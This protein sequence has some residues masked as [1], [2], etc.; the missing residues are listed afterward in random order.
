MALYA[1]D[2]TWEYD[3]K[4]PDQDT[5]VIRFRDAYASGEVVY[6]PGV[7]TRFG[8]LGHIVGAVT[9]AGGRQRVHE[10]I[11]AFRRHQTAGDTTVDIVGFSRG[12]ALALHFANALP[13]ETTIRFLGLFD[14]VP[15]FGIPGNNIDLGWN[16]GFP[17]A[18]ERCY[19]AMALNETRYNFPLHRL[20][21]HPQLNEV[22][23]RGVHS[24]VGGG[25]GNPGLSS[26]ALDWMFDSAHRSGL[27]LKTSKV[28]ANRAQIDPSAPV[29][30][31]KL[32]SNLHRRTPRPGDSLH[33]SVR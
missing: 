17:P 1:F 6:L 11:E 15:S 26:I 25:N 23:F 22:W 18:A 24:D 14:T 32:T 20:E 33:P 9:G 21:P 5:N 27:E 12:A 7:G 3:F 16:L 29:S 19:H 8:W 31:V 30:V 4:N 10:A 13:E 2:G 28:V